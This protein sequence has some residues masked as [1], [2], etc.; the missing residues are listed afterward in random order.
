[1]RH[2]LPRHHALENQPMGISIGLQLPPGQLKQQR[3]PGCFVEDEKLLGIIAGHACDTYPPRPVEA[4]TSDHHFTLHHAPCHC[5]AP[6]KGIGVGTCRGP[7][8]F[9]QGVPGLAGRIIPVDRMAYESAWKCIGTHHGHATEAV[10]L[11]VFIHYHHQFTAGA[12]FP[13]RS[14]QTHTVGVGP[15]EGE[16]QRCSSV[17]QGAAQRLLHQVVVAAAL[18]LLVE[19]ADFSPWRPPL[20]SELYLPGGCTAD[21]LLHL[22]EVGHAR[23]PV[24]L[25][26]GFPGMNLHETVQ[27]GE[28]IADV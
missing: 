24:D 13:Q 22:F 3:L 25:G 7:H 11:Q 15:P 8:A 4:T 21:L 17:R 6:R 26:E 27:P 9:E 2:L 16:T 14:A 23:I 5:V 1:M 19:R 20:A 12:Q 28:A 10:G 18:A